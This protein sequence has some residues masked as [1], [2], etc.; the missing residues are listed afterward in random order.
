MAEY[1]CKLCNFNTKL[2]T[3]YTNHLATEKHKNNSIFKNKRGLYW[4]S[5][6]KKNMQN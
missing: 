4:T 5:W 2:K 1:S 6:T 3:N